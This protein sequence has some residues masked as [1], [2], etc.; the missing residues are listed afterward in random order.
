MDPVEKIETGGATEVTLGE[1]VSY[2]YER[3]SK[4]FDN[5]ELLNL[6][7]ASKVDDILAH[8]QDF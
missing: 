6:A 4:L 1:L 5:P 3:F 8:N 7:V 2:Y